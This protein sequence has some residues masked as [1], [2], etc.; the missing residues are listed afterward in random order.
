[1]FKTIVWATDGSDAADRALE[2]AKS[3][4]SG[5]DKKLFGVHS[6]EHFSGGRST[7]YPVL[8]DEEDFEVELQNGVLQIVFEEPAP[9]KFVVSPNAPV[10]QVDIKTIRPTVFSYERRLPLT[11]PQADG[12]DSGEPEKGTVVSGKGI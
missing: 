2:Y 1:M 7:G 3:I 11:L 9:S 5:K 4:A 8:A 12:L 10:R 6:N